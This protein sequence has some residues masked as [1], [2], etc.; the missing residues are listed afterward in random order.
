M[1]A[2]APEGPQ[3]TADLTAFVSRP[4]AR[5]P[6]PSLTHLPTAYASL[7]FLVFEPQRRGKEG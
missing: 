1:D 7:S 6:F 2:G 5:P 3:S 4:S